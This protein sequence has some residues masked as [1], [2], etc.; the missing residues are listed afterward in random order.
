MVMKASEFDE[1]TEEVNQF[2]LGRAER[3]EKNEKIAWRV[4]AASLGLV[5][6]AIIA[7]MRLFPLKQV[8]H[9]VLIV[10]KATG[11]ISRPMTI[12][13]ARIELDE[14][15]MKH[16]VALFIT[17]REGY[18]FD[19]SEKSY[20]DAAA[21]MCPQQQEEWGKLWEPANPKN[22]MN[23]YGKDGKVKIDI[24]SI[25]PYT[26]DSGKTTRATV[27]YKRTVVTPSS[28]SEPEYRVASFSFYYAAVSKKQKEQIV[29][30]SG[31]QICDYR[32]DPV[33]VTP[34]RARPAQ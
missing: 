26:N 12:E 15:F 21:L 8:I 10:D 17:A 27:N 30:P 24:E 18:T 16:F 14:A 6:L 19:G 20:Y 28:V 29:N 32:T 4:A 3:A 5:A 9:E 34:Q 7:G 22:P 25:Q 2:A 13:E 31:F 23:V 33:T 11:E 1:Y